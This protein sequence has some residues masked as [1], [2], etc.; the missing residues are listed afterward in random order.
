M[1]RREGWRRRSGGHGSCLHCRLGVSRRS[2][3]A[4]RKSSAEWRSPSYGTLEPLKA[5]WLE[6]ARAPEWLV[7]ALHYLAVAALGLSR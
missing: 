1:D 4:K 7:A 6:L 5:L 2:P 3:K